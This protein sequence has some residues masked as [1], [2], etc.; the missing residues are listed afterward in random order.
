[1]CVCMCLRDMDIFFLSHTWTIASHPS[2]MVWSMVCVG[3]GWG[4]GSVPI[5]LSV[6]RLS[7]LSVP[8]NLAGDGRAGVLK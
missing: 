8:L 6:Y 5:A 7:K 1:M 3:S 4:S 2:F